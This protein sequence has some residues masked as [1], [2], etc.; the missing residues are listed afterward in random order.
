MNKSKTTVDQERVVAA[1]VRAQNRHPRTAFSSL[2][3][4]VLEEEFQRCSY[5]SSRERAILAYVLELRPEVVQ[6]IFQ[7]QCRAI[8][9]N[10][11]PSFDFNLNNPGNSN[12][13]GKLNSSSKRGFELTDGVDCRIQFAILKIDSY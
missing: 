2:Q 12:S 10:D 6:V 4:R 1:K 8:A 9:W 3:K 7:N 5:P 11:M 13:E